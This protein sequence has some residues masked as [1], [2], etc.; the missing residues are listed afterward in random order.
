MGNEKFDPNIYKKLD[1]REEN[2]LKKVFERAG[3]DLPYK[4]TVEDGPDT[5]VVHM[6]D[7]DG[8]DV[9]M[10]FTKVGEKIIL[11]DGNK[12]CFSH[13]VEA[14]MRFPKDEVL[15]AIKKLY[16]KNP[17]LKEENKDNKGD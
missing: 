13:I 17:E 7:S 8:K 6:K 5:V 12:Y 16:D 1:K 11:A 4:F 14:R 10:G 2:R 9:G 15:V 3:L